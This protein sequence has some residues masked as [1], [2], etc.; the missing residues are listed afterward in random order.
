MSKQKNR[1][2]KVWKEDTAD[3]ASQSWS[4]EERRA[5][6]EMEEMER[7]AAEENPIHIPA[8]G[9][10]GYPIPDQVKHVD[11]ETLYQHDLREMH[12]TQVPTLED[13][14][15]RK[16][17]P[18]VRTITAAPQQGTPLAPVPPAMPL[19]EKITLSIRGTVTLDVTFKCNAI[20]I[21]QYI[22]ALVISLDKADEV[23]DISI[24][25]PDTLAFLTT[26]QGQQIPIYF[27]TIK[28]M[29]YDTMG[30]RHILF[31]IKA[32]NQQESLIS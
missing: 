4:E 11:L 3:S 30:Y 1:S 10:G 13:S 23:P 29:Q 16:V 7:I 19:S 27:P 18:T 32:S 24:T 15:Q 5:Q 14:P 26:V 12:Q 25:D 2:T 22:A 8:L 9:Q 28:E 21:T 6:K 20:V 31:F 17:L